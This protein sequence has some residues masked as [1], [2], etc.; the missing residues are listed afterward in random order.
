MCKDAG[1]VRIYW[2]VLA[3]GSNAMQHVSHGP[4]C[5]HVPIKPSG[6]NVPCVLIL[7]LCVLFVYDF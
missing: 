1:G 6:G 7:I 5:A 4:L 2:K 3:A